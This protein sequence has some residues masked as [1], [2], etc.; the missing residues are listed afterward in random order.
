MAGISPY[1]SA[2]DIS[3][4]RGG[5]ESPRELRPNPAGIDGGRQLGQTATPADRERDVADLLS[6]DRE[7][8]D[9][10]V[11][12]AQHRLHRMPGG[13]CRTLRLAAGRA[14]PV[15]GRPLLRPCGEHS[16]TECGLRDEPPVSLLETWSE[17]EP[18]GRGRECGAAAHA[19][20]APD[21]GPRCPTARRLKGK[22]HTRE[23]NDAT[24]R[25]VSAPRLLRSA[26]LA[27]PL[28]GAGRP[29]RSAGARSS[30]TPC[31]GTFR[32]RPGAVPPR[33]PCEQPWTSTALGSGW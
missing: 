31:R 13:R 1:A 24:L 12:I 7:H 14:R 11:G 8:D 22:A 30:R 27:L 29:P 33:P 5:R 2:S 28:R 15:G 19:D 6:A 21:R 20:L 9:V 3:W 4:P 26:G 25:S 32:E 10:A 17:P 18:A 23:R 16:T